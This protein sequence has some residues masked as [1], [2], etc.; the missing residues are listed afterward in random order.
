MSITK[1]QLRGVAENMF[2]EIDTNKNGA[3][4]KEEVREFSKRMM[5][6]LKPDATFDEVAFEENFAALD[7]N[8]DGRVDM[9]ELWIS[10]VEKA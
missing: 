7:K 4:E 9:S 3:L 5:E 8:K 2:T 10:L 6:T 1:E